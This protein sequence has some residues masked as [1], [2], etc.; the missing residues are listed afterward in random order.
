M[1]NENVIYF[2][3]TAR[4][5]YGTKSPET[6]IK[7][8]IQDMKFLLSHNVK[9]VIVACNTAS[10]TSI[11]NLRKKFHGIPVIGVIK[12]AIDLAMICTSNRRIGIIGTEGTISSNAYKKE[13]EKINPD[14]KVFGRACP[15]FVPLVEE[16][17]NDSREAVLIAQKYLKPLKERKIDTL[18]L[19]CTHYP[20]LRKL[21]VKIMGKAITIIDS[22]GVVAEETKEVLREK[23]L[24]R[25]SSKNGKHI[26]FSSDNP[27]RFKKIGQRFLGQKL[28]NVSKVDIEK[29]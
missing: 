2:G 25:E 29:Y 15:L 21:I 18:I 5:P 13:I 20:L 12:P 10:A 1:P 7:F 16:G 19:G 11:E 24:I 17:W 23:G 14:I 3:D 27:G 22:A 6:V 8:S 4:V 9:L 26:F 28:S